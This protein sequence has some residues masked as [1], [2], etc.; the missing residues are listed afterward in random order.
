MRDTQAGA[1]SVA[2][3]SDKGENMANW[4]AGFMELQ[5]WQRKTNRAIAKTV[6]ELIAS[7][8]GAAK[9]KVTAAM[10]ASR[11]DEGRTDDEIRQAVDEWFDRH[12]FGG[13]GGR[14]KG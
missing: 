5:R 11:R 2:A 8:G 7:E 13:F 3:Q 6:E 14:F 10:L 9:S 4:L 12:R 1:G